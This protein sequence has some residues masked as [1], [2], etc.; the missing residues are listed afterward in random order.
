MY[1]FINK[2]ADLQQ[3]KMKNIYFFCNIINISQNT[4][5]NSKYFQHIY[6]IFKYQTLGDQIL[7]LKMYFS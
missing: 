2:L 7:W 1:V 3:E 4:K 6:D 5:K